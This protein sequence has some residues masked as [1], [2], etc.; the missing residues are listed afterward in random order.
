MGLFSFL[1]GDS[2]PTTGGLL[3]QSGATQKAYQDY[4]IDQQSQ[5]KQPLTFQE[6][7]KQQQAIQAAKPKQ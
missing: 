2:K 6:W 3:P 7:M 1:F 5:G 4:A